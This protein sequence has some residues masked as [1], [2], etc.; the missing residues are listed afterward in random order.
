MDISPEYVEKYFPIF[1]E[2]KKDDYISNED[3][4]DPDPP[5]P[6]ANSYSKG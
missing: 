6:N 5:A 1:V 2:D 4:F 3:F